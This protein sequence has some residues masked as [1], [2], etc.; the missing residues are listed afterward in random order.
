MVIDNLEAW[1]KEYFSKPEN[2]QKSVKACERYDR[3]MVKN[4][5]RQLSSGMEQIKLNE[6]PKDDP[7]K[8][9]EKIKYEILSNVEF[10][11]QKGKLRINLIDQTASFT[12]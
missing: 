3:L 2:Q 11:G 4:I 9:L 5:K 8:C 6:L 1:T 7:G 12:S 10:Q